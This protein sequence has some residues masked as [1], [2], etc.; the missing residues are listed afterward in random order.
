MLYVVYTTFCFGNLSFL[1]HFNTIE[2]LISEYLKRMWVPYFYG[3]E[4]YA[5]GL[6]HISY[7]LDQTC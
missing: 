5:S 6:T 2:K 7:L 4:L 3:Q 1:K